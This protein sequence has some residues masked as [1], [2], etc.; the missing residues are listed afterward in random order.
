MARTSAVKLEKLLPK[1][2]SVWVNATR[3]D[4]S[5]S[6]T[7]WVTGE[8][9]QAIVDGRLQLGEALSELKLA[10]ALG[11]SRT[12]VREALNALQLQGLIDIRPQ[13]GSFVFLPS[14]ENVGE[15]AEFR[16]VLEVAALRFCFARRREAARR[17]LHDATEAM[18]RAMEA[19]DRL[20]IAGADAAFHQSIVG[21]SANEFLIGAYKLISGR[22]GALLT[23]NLADRDAVSKRSNGEHRAVAAAFAKGDIE[24]AGAILDE[25]VSRMRIVYS[26]ARRVVAA[27]D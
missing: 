15:L 5:S 10:G 9:R 16:R 1:H 19:G 26:A 20:A 8:I 6:L 7:D 14:E 2:A 3:R 21:N 12:P 22:I 13:S 25:H 23:Y 18:D 24:L 17:E 27:A 11:V 4:A